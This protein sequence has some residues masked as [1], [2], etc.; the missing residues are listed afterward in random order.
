[1][2]KLLVIVTVTLAILLSACGTAQ[3]GAEDVA[4]VGDQIITM[5]DI[6][7]EIQR[8]PPYQRT[9]FETLRGK[10]ALLDHIIERE[11]ILLAAYDAGLAED[12]AVLAMVGTAEEQVEAVRTRAM[13]QVFYQTMIIESVEI[14]DSLIQE[15][16]NRNI[17]QYRNDPVAL[18]SHILISS[19]DADKLAEAQ[20]M[21]NSGMPFDSVAMAVSEHSATA[22][23]GGSIGWTGENLDIP[24]IGEDQG[25]LA[26]LLAT[27]AGTILPPYET[28]LGTH[29][30]LVKEQQD[31]YYSS[32]EDVRT[33]IEEMLRPALVNDFFQNTFMVEL[34]ETY[35]V[36]VNETPV[37][38]IYATVGDSEITE[39]DV[40]AELEAIP[41]YQRESYETAEGKQLI[42]D[43]MIERE[44]INLASIEAGLDTDSSVVAQVAQAE[45]QVEETLR[46]ALIQEYYQRYIVETAEVAEEDILA[47]YEDHTGDIYKQQP[48]IKVSAIFTDSQDDMVLVEDAIASG[49]T[50]EDAAAQFSTHA[51]TAAINGELGWVPLNAPLPYISQD[52][53]FATEMYSSEIGSTFG[54]VRTELGIVLI[55][56]TDKLEE[57]V[58]PLEEVRESIEAA[59][60]PGIVNS[61]MYD[62][63]F[64]ELRLKYAVEINESAFLPSE[65]IGAD[66]LMT[67]AQEAMA[68]DPLTAVEYFKL[69][70]HRY[71]E[72]ERCDQAQFLIGFTF[73]EQIKDF[74]AART[75]FG[76]LV[77]NYPDSE[78]AD[79]AEWM[80]ENMEIPIEEFIPAEAP[81]E[82]TITE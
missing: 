9:T 66:S 28:N 70:L 34:R 47:Y 26:L 27:E 31:E 21:L 30:F 78:L 20:E 53:D 37:N 6:N 49:T 74:D 65:S 24:F 71:P 36:S 45:K 75:A 82:E 1:M 54:P 10:R 23:Q 73:S 43:S 50:F 60:R 76:L 17:E 22:P 33:G 2:K 7:S 51:P 80:I 29:I 39:A 11:L 81:A 63:I 5:E 52:F 13:G 68:V 61:Y 19:D 15:Y 62:T 42:I 59:L 56:V 32:L 35:T 46:G 72:N 67:L 12:S 40:L 69:F 64:P 38:G 44:L 18:V 41:P 25:L 8:I 79:D 48:Q 4:R 3:L 55:K 16:Y 14:P 77:E 58:K 57:G